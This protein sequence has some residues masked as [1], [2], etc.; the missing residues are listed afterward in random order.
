M[1]RFDC[2]YVE[3]KEY[4]KYKLAFSDAYSSGDACQLVYSYGFF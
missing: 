3:H 4:N 1:G 2:I